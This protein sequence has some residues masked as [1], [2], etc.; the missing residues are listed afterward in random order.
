MRDIERLA[1]KVTENVNSTTLSEVDADLESS[2]SSYE[3][4][5]NQAR[6]LTERLVDN[7]ALPEL[8]LNNLS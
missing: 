1:N 3:E 8:L 2:Q 5:L 7:G 4:K 6:A